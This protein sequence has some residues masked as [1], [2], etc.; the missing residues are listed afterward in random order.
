MKRLTASGLALAARC[1]AAYALPHDEAASTDAQAAGHGRHA[2]LDAIVAA[3]DAEPIAEVILSG[4]PIGTWLPMLRDHALATVPADAPHRATCESIDVAELFELTGADEGEVETGLTFAWRHD[5]DTAE[6]LTVEAHRAYPDVMGIPGTLDWLVTSPEGRVCVIDFK[7]SEAVAPTRENLQ[8]LA[9]AL[10]VARSRSLD[11]IDVAIVY[12]HEDGHLVLDRASLDVFALDA[13]A[14]R[15]ASIWEG[16]RFA[17][18]AADRGAVDRTST[19][20]HCIRCPAMSRCPAMVTMVREF[21]ASPPDIAAFPKLSDEE[22]GAAWERFA[23]LDALLS[24]GRATLRQRAERRGL[25]LPDGRWLTP[26]EVARKS[27]DVRK[28]LPVLRDLVGD[29]ADAEVEQSL[30][31]SA[32]DAIA[33]EVARAR[34]ETLK[35]VKA[36]VWE[37]LGAAHAVKTSTHIQ[38]KPRK[39]RGSEADDA[40]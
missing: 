32:V 35:S 6:A 22:A 7:G 37:R 14:A 27:V 25:P 26:V 23:L 15:L 24:Q 19:G 18:E 36:A 28:A 17:R 21:L 29:R 30:P 39:V 33:A 40:A 20:E 12:V 31:T 16:V 2:F 3:Y 10:M 9:Y 5:D 1:P 13:A 38:L 8:L 4:A 11:E 34:G